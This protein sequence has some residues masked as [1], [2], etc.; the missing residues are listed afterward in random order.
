MVILNY[1]KIFTGRL[2]SHSQ[3][4]TMV[5]TGPDGT[6]FLNQTFSLSQTFIIAL[7]LDKKWINQRCWTSINH[8]SSS[9]LTCLRISFIPGSNERIH[10]LPLN[11]TEDSNVYLIP[12]WAQKNRIEDD[13]WLKAMRHDSR[14]TSCISYSTIGNHLPWQ[15]VTKWKQNFIYLFIYLTA[16]SV[17]G[18]RGRCR[19]L[20]Q[21][22]SGKGKGSSLNELPVHRKA[23]FE[24]LGVSA[25]LKGTSAVL[26]S[27]P[28]P[29]KGFLDGIDVMHTS[30]LIIEIELYIHLCL[31]CAYKE[32]IC[33]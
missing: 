15:K 1:G 18:S 12:M 30:S 11:H 9:S 27:F 4:Y 8:P 3:L 5:V 32:F 29:A 19:G 6:F 16:F 7:F 26:W 28:S 24:N 14:K 20:S 10:T 23:L 22:Q 17:A 31:N 13:M 21:L 2:P 25:L 33:V